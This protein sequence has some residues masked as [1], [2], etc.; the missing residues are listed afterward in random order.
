MDRYFDLIY[1][2]FGVLILVALTYST[3]IALDLRHGSAVLVFRKRALGIA[4][5]SIGTIIV[6]LAGFLA[7]AFLKGSVYFQQATFACYYIGFALITFG[8]NATAGATQK[9]Y[10]LPK[11][12]ANTNFSGLVVWC[13]FLGTL[14]L[15]VFYLVN[16]KTFVFNQNG[17][18]VQ[19]VVYWIP[20]LATTFAGA[21]LLFSLASQIKDKGEQKHLL[22][23]GAY[24]TLVF[25]GLLGESSILPDLGSP[26]TNLLVIFVP[27]TIGSFCLSFGVRNLIQ[28]EVA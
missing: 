27:F 13:L 10:P 28:K 22:W 24:A 26:L 21:T 14:A 3:F 18:Q 25:V 8:L 5:A 7:N 16:P 19:R 1:Y 17:V 9:T 11:H 15:S 12:L 2:T 23:I 6:L 4:F 20:M